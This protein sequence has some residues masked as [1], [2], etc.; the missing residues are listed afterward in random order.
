MYG[1]RTAEEF[2]ESLHPE[3]ELYPATVVPDTGDY[4]GR[5]EFLRGVRHWLEEWE[6]FRFIPEEVVDLGER[7]LMRV[8]LSG[9][10]KASGV[11]LDETVFH[12]WSFKDGMPWRCEFLD[13]RDA[14]EAARRSPP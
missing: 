2:A 1:R 10:A 9:R 12:L 5:G 4:H 8:R 6:T 14:L 7:V 3:A 11:E 13:E